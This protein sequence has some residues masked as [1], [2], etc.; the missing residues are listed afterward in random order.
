MVLGVTHRSLMLLI[1]ALFWLG[2]VGHSFAAAQMQAGGTEVA[3]SEG[4]LSHGDCDGCGS[5][6]MFASDA[7]C[8]AV[9]ATPTIL[10]AGLTTIDSAGMRPQVTP[11]DSPLGRSGPP[12]PY[13]PRAV[14]LS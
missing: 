5:D 7:A 9:C 8:Q 12:E 13:P 1:V 6:Q 2:S 3:V 11:S 4:M 14:V 10:A